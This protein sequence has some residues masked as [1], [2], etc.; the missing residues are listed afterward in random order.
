MEFKKY[1]QNNYAYNEVGKF[2][3]IPQK[4]K[5][6]GADGT[7]QGSFSQVLIIL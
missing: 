2:L 6:P 1:R 4:E 3:K 7:A 5:A